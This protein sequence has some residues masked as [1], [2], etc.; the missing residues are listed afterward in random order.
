MTRVL[1]E[2]FLL[3]ENVICIGDLNLEILHSLY[4][5]Q[6]KCLLDISD[7]YDLDSLVN[8]PTRVSENRSS[9]LYVILTNAPAFTRD[10]GVIGTGLSDH[11][12]VYTVLNTKLLRPKSEATIRRSF[13]KFHQDAFHDDLVKCRSRLH[14]CLMIQTMSIGAGKN[15]INK[16]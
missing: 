15:S 8:K 9:C 2:A 5:K 1:D 6:G 11:C 7:I 12:L 13:K 3:C 10:S 14:T 16:S 4:N